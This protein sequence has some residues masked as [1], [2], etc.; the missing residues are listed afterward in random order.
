MTLG[1]GPLTGV[2]VLDMTRFV[3]GPYCT[4]LLGDAGADVIKVE[5]L[6]GEETRELGPM[7]PAPDGS[8]ISGYFL[9]FARNKRSLCLDLAAPR[10]KE[11]FSRLLEGADV[12]VENFRPGV[13]ARLGFSYEEIRERHPRLI[14]CTISGFGH[15]DSPQQKDPAFAILAEVLGGVVVRNTHEGEPPVWTGLGLGDLYPSALAV[16]GV[17]MALFQRERTG[18]GAH[19]DM[20]MYDGMVSVNERV[21]AM[22]SMTGREHRPGGG[23]VSYNAP[24]GLFHAGGGEYVCIAV[25]GEK[26][27]KRFCSVIGKPRLAEDPALANG[28]MRSRSLEEVLRPEIEGWLQEMGR[29]RAVELLVAGGIPAGPIRHAAEILS[30]PQTEAR[31]M[32]VE[33]GSYAGVTAKVSGN[34]IKVTSPTNGAPAERARPAA[35]PGADTSAVLEEVAGL[36]ADEIAEL[37]EAG[38]VEQWS[39]SAVGATGDGIGMKD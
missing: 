28:E 37:I 23:Q 20:A 39:A 29:D 34:P 18:A 7:L 8:T 36:A 10:G 16:G 5:P 30:H 22:T 4:M 6:G 12:L 33:Y 13:L 3:A 38:V 35:A 17:S 19:V 32:V 25:I 21:I 26:L 9:R 24:F 31:N 27:W 15:S 1:E 11:V 14:Y 2:R